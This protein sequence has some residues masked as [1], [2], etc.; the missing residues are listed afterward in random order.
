MFPA[1]KRLGDPA[2]SAIVMRLQH[3]HRAMEV[4]WQAVRGLLQ[5]VVDCP[6]TQHLALGAY[7]LE[8]VTRF[9]LALY[10]IR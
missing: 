9:F 7:A 10:Q 5:D 1:I 3:G 4:A 2:L 8:S 6:A